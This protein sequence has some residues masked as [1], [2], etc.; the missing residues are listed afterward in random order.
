M[1]Y[2][3]MSL[4]AALALAMPGFWQE[5]ESS[6]RSAPQLLPD[7]QAFAKLLGSIEQQ[8]HPKSICRKR[9]QAKFQKIAAA[10]Q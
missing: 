4:V 1:E 2:R 10:R 9:R 6:K 5:N 7:R 3:V 8:D